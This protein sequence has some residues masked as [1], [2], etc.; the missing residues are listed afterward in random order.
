MAKLEKDAFKKTEA[1][2]RFLNGIKLSKTGGASG[3]DTMSGRV[4]PA[5]G[6]RFTIDRGSPLG[7]GTF[8][9]VYKGVDTQT[10]Q[11][12]AVKE[13]RDLADYREEVKNAQALGCMA[14]FQC[15]LGAEI[16][17]STGYIAYRLANGDVQS[18]VKR[19]MRPV[20]AQNLLVALMRSVAYLRSK[21]LVHRDIKPDNVLYYGD[22]PEYIEFSL[23]D[24][25]SMC[26]RTEGNS[27]IPVCTKKMR[28]TQ[29]YAPADVAMSYEY[30][31]DDA[32]KWVDLYGLAATV[33]YYATGGQIPLFTRPPT[34]IPGDMLAP[35][36][37]EGVLRI[38][39]ADS[40]RGASD[41][42]HDLK[43]KLRL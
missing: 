42:Y 13:F 15:L 38:L 4:T 32:M 6:G 29:A 30:E 40:Y 39:Q 2:L 43:K 23:G 8:G 9:S 21:E 31:D 7:S 11:E 28:T 35:E 14:D 10:G 22:E 37:K 17:G 24:L 3:R 33:Y 26:S 20:V 19:P 27:N 18:L 34:T 5:R 25:G 41:A 12:V 16:V 36:L 1:A